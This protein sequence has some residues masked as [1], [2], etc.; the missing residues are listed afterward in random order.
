MVNIIPIMENLTTCSCIVALELITWQLVQPKI[1]YCIQQICN[2]QNILNLL[3]PLLIVFI[4][5]LHCKT[6]SR[7][8]RKDFKIFLFPVEVWKSIDSLD[9]LF[10][11][12][13]CIV[14]PYLFL[15]IRM[16]AICL[17][18]VYTWQIFWAQ[19]PVGLMCAY[20]YLQRP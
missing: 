10:V 3:K 15:L 13:S 17:P 4:S 1:I 9:V 2:F 16:Q 18:I 6:V 7:P 14:F 20:Y 19:C 11:S 8:S 5:T 12:L